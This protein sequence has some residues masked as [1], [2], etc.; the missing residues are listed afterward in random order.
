M[1]AT[2]VQKADRL[3]NEYNVLYSVHREGLH[4]VPLTSILLVT[5]LK[6]K[7]G[8]EIYLVT[9]GEQAEEASKEMKQFLEGDFNISQSELNQVDNLLQ[10]NVITAEN[11][12]S[13]IESG[14]L[15]V[16]NQHTIIIYNT[17]A[18]HLFGIPAR[19][20]LGRKVTE[21]FPDSR[22]PEVVDT[23]EPILGYTREIGK[24]TIVVNTTPIIENDEIKGAISTFEDVSRLV[25][26]SWE[27]EEVKEI[28]ERY[29]Q[30][31]RSRT[32]R[33]LCV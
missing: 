16:D 30:I 11:V 2:I 31:F 18:E 1:A 28:K 6:V 24:S 9:E 15:V 4:N 7:K 25:Q 3:Q 22:L 12:Y 27:C 23:K 14:L 8:E 29:L 32:G 21:V 13:N 26:I 19:E 33:D 17:E 5:A 10:D 20:V